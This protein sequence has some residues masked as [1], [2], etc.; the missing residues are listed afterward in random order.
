MTEENQS[1]LGGLAQNGDPL[2]SDR[3]TLSEEATYLIE[4]AFEEFEEVLVNYPHHAAYCFVS[5]TCLSETGEALSHFARRLGMW[6]WIEVLA[7][8]IEEPL[9]LREL[10]EH[11]DT[12]MKTV[13]LGIDELVAVGEFKIEWERETQIKLTPCLLKETAIQFADK[14]LRGIESGAQAEGA[15]H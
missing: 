6:I 4:L 7:F 3:L 15:T 1:N 11:F 5:I 14:V 10:T 12:D 8:Q 9:N 13:Q 2:N